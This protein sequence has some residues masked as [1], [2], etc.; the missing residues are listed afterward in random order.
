MTKKRK[1]LKA[2]HPVR[3]KFSNG[4]AKDPLFDGCTL[5]EI[6]VYEC[7]RKI[8]HGQTRSY[9]WVA[10][11]VGKPRAARAVAQALKRNP[12]PLIIPCHRVV[13]SNGK[14]GGYAYGVELKKIF[15][16]LEKM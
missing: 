9:A 7:I 10:K 15:L 8:P 14:L 13:H 4:A 6:D 11:A 2:V 3:K 5:F 16:K 12:W 1:S